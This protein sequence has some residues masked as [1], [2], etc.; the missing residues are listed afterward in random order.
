MAAGPDGIPQRF[1][2]LEHGSDVWDYG[3]CYQVHY[4]LVPPKWWI[5]VLTGYEESMAH[6]ET[7]PWEVMGAV[8]GDVDEFA[9]IDNDYRWIDGK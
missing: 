9:W 2:Y 6:F 8:I 4:A 7:N 1:K 3:V 5:E